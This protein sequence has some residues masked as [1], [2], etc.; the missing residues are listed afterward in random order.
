M[1]TQPFLRLRYH[2]GPFLIATTET[3][4]GYFETLVCDRDFNDNDPLRLSKRFSSCEEAQAWHHYAVK[5]M[6][7]E[8]TK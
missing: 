2:I 7:A 8:A 1:K 5:R 3:P 4:H 6:K